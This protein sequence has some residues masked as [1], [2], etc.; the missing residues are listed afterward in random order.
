MYA[1]FILPNGKR[2]RR[3]ARTKDRKEAEELR[4]KLK[5][6]AW[7]VS[8]MGDKPKRLWDEAAVRWIH[9]KSHKKSI[10]DDIA[11]IRMLTQLRGVY[12][13]HMTKDLIQSV[14]SLLPCQNSTKNRYLSLIRSILRAAVNK[15]NWLD[16]MPYIEL[17]KESGG[18]IRWLT[19]DEAQRLIDAATP[20][21]FSELIVFSLNTGLRQSNVLNLKWSQIDLHRK[22]AW[23]FPD[24]MKSGKALGVALNDT[25]IEV[26][27]RQIGKHPVYVFVNG[28]G[29]PI[30]G[31]DSRRWSET[32]SRAGIEDFTWH[33][34]RHTWA[35]WLVQRGVPL[36]VLQEMGGW[37]TLG[38]VQRYAHLA[39]EHLHP[40]AKIL[41][42]LV[43]ANDTKMAHIKKSANDL[44][45]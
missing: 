18:R 38:M 13:H 5:Y 4:D 33:D 23:Y 3:T 1:D 25:A 11:K 43:D 45:S 28:R 32:L 39:P 15:L 16:V 41:Q 9:E 37:K 42:G 44:V 2:I 35:S 17:Y 10:S 22:V 40:H 19:P 29:N 34:L 12:L 24:E 20:R 6:E 7:R 36:R 30:S 21:Y 31:I 8:Q 27:R 14:V 26:I